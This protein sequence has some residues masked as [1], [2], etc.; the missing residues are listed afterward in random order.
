MVVVSLALVGGYSGCKGGVTFPPRRR[1]RLIS[2]VQERILYLALKSF[3]RTE[4]LYS[5]RLFRFHFLFFPF[6][7]NGWKSE[8]FFSL[9]LS[10]S[11]F[12]EG[13]PNETRENVLFLLFLFFF[14][15]CPR[16]FNSVRDKKVKQREKRGLNPG[17]LFVVI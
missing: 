12:F 1:P 7:G 15:L 3:S 14:R 8:N 13:D 11:S 4:P 9:S 2:S 10:L 6:V 16:S 17:L 5:A